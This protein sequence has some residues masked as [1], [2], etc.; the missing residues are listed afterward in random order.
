MEIKARNVKQYEITD[1]PP[2]GI[3]SEEQAQELYTALCATL[4]KPEV[5]YRGCTN[6]LSHSPHFWGSGNYCTGRS[7]DAT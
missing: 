7:F 4:G 1:L 5:Q 3:F 6:R 2:D